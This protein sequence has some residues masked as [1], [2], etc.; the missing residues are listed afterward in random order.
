MVRV[1][2]QTRPPIAVHGRGRLS[3]VAD[4]PRSAECQLS[5]GGARLVPKHTQPPSTHPPVMTVPLRPEET[6]PPVEV[7]PSIGLD[8][9]PETP[10]GIRPPSRLVPSRRSPRGCR[11]SNDSAYSRPLRRGT[12]HRRNMA[13]PTSVGPCHPGTPR[14]PVGRRTCSRRARACAVGVAKRSEVACNELAL[15]HPCRPNRRVP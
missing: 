14:L 5:D 4:A 15:G 13:P 9:E 3:T 1:V 7:G 8:G 2:G 12:H 11:R 10:R 6:Q